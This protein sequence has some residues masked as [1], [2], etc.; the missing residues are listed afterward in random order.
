M[1]W[2]TPRF[3]PY[4]ESDC[5]II[6]HYI[7]S[8]WHVS[9]YRAEPKEIG[10][11]LSL[12]N[13]YSTLLAVFLVQKPT[14]VEIQMLC[15]ALQFYA[16]SR[17]PGMVLDELRLEHLAAAL[18]TPRDQRLTQD[19]RYAVKEGALLPLNTQE[20][21][22]RAYVFTYP[23]AQRVFAAIVD[24]H[25]ETFH[26]SFTFREYFRISRAFARDASDLDGMFI[27]SLDAMRA[28]LVHFEPSETEIEYQPTGERVPM[29]AFCDPARR[30]EESSTCSVCMADIECGDYP[31]PIAQ[32]VCKHF[33]HPKCLDSWVNDSGMPASNTCPSCRRV[34]CEPRQRAHPTQRDDFG[35]SA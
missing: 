29:R 12:L 2:K 35:R 26:R 34:L 16:A 9:E 15:G 11:F 19:A 13:K 23:L 27:P 31:K 8:L 18:S 7:P 28:Q 6:R 14:E 17:C 33:F 32:T 5:A 24:E 30:I 10:C 4:S 25:Q 22:D 3:Q 20:A 1:R 21:M